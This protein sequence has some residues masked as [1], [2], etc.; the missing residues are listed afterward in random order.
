MKKIWLMPLMLLSL[1]ATA[2]EAGT[3]DSALERRYID[4]VMISASAGKMKEDLA[5][6]QMGRIDIPISMLS[7]APS[8]AGEPD[9]LKALQLTPGVKRGVEGGIGTYVRGGNK[10][11]NLMLLD[12]APV[13]NAG[14]LLGFFSVFNTAVLKDVQLYKSSFPSLYGGRLS[15]VTDIRTKDG[16]MSRYKASL[17]LGVISSSACIQG[18]LLNDKLSFM[19]AGRR[20]YLDQ[21]VKTIPY[22]FYDANLK[23]AY[24]PDDN[25]RVWLSLYKGNDVMDMQ[26]QG[27]DGK[28]SGFIL[29]SGMKLGN[30]IAS[31]RWLYR[32]ADANYSRELTAYY[33]GFHYRVDGNLRSN[34]LR[35]SSDIK[36][37]GLKGAWKWQ[38]GIHAVNAG[39]NAAYRLFHP[40]AVQSSGSALEQFPSRAGSII[41]NSEGAVHIQDDMTLSGCWQLHAGFRLSGSLAGKKVYLNPEP[42]L[43]LRYLIDERN[44][45]K[46]SY[47]RMAQYMQLV[48]SASLSLPTDLW[49]PV[50]E[51][52]LPGISDQV[53]AGYYHVLPS[54]GISLSAEVYYKRMKNLV[55]YREGALLVMNDDYE[56]EMVR[57]KGNAYGIELFA[58]RTEGRFSG[59]VGYALSY[60]NRSFDSLNGGRSYAARYDR[61]HDLSLVGMV[62]IS[63]RWAVSTSVLYATGAPFTGQ[64]GQYI[65]PKPDFGGFDVLPVY[66]SRNALRLSASFRIDLDLQYKFRIGKHIAGDAHLS[67]YNLLNRTQ[68]S[69]VTRTW[70]DERKE[71]VYKQEGLFGMITAASVNINL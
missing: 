11:E 43:A 37:M 32:P 58:G 38:M 25:N 8:L 57:G 56:R 49:Y 9:V 14:H 16:S 26:E 39:F 19:L 71:Y 42:R 12:G 48:S 63:R 51:S 23:L 60:A 13:Y 27:S 55:E 21:F 2:Q 20:T 10:D 5:A 69:R 29:N 3:A 64:Q 6:A 36:D 22:H 54:L 28:S 47:A 33:S 50:T 66:T 70:S 65:V 59:W 7:K 4:E 45:I 1:P 40:N 17:G 31:L 44:S 53:S 61:R 68:P 41:G 62:E 24:R 67:V 18:P 30:N 52:I 35:V 46:M 15:S 34:Y